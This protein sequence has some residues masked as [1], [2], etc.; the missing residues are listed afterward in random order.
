MPDICD[1]I[2]EDHQRF[3]RRF[4]ELDEL[5]AA[6]ADPDV[7]DRAWVPVAE[8][9]E[10]HAA[11]EEAL[12]YPRLLPRGDDAHDETKDAITDHNDIR[13]AVRRAGGTSAGSD[14]WWAAVLDA[15]A[16]NSDHMGE[17]ERGAIPDFR[18]HA[19]GQLREDLGA[20]WVEFEA[21]HAGARDVDT[22]DKDPDRYIARHE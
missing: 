14:G 4:A 2:L 21:R 13:D 18:Q 12:F 8:L 20:R 1:L 22:S 7:L 16:K 9:L 17:E 5:R 10:V 15:R 11:A 19:D 6:R 3:R